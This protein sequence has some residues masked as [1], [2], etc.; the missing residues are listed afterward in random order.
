MRN[1]ESRA[2]CFVGSCTRQGGANGRPVTHP[3]RLEATLCPALILAI[4]LYVK[5]AR[6]QDGQD[7][8]DPPDYRTSQDTKIGTIAAVSNAFSP[9]ATPAKAPATGLT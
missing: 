7:R 8:R 1:D 3:E 5:S 2:N 6:R 4:V 9:I